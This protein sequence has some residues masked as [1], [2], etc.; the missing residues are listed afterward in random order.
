M[1]ALVAS[2]STLIRRG[3]PKRPSNFSNQSSSATVALSILLSVLVVVV[4][5]ETKGLERKH[6]ALVLLFIVHEVSQGHL[7]G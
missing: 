7:I 1:K 3:S 2:S 4:E 5:V 6:S